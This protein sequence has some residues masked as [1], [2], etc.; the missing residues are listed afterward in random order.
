LTIQIIQPWSLGFLSCPIWNKYLI[1]LKETRGDGEERGEE[2]GRERR[3]EGER[4]RERETPKLRIA[5]L[6]LNS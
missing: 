1:R 6:L 3:G 5:E 4:E 2:R